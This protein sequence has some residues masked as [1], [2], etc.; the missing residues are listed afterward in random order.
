MTGLRNRRL[1][2]YTLIELAT[3]VAVVGILAAIAY[4]GYQYSIQ[5]TR[6]SDAKTNL[7]SLAQRLERCY[8]Q[9]GTYTP[10][11][12]GGASLCPVTSPDTTS[13]PYY[14]ITT[15]RTATTFSLTATTAGKQTGDTKCAS[16][17]LTNTGARS[18]TGTDASGCW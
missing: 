10:L 4:P 15:T 17:T 6:R 18:A 7:N 13:T 11:D 14:S 2:G 12:A 8:T 1:A 9:F 5:K 16:F 3:V